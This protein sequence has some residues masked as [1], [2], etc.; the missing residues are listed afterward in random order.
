MYSYIHPYIH[1]CILTSLHPYIPTNL[2][3]YMPAYLHAYMHTYTHLYTYIPNASIQHIYTCIYTYTNIR[4][5]TY[6]HLYMYVYED[7]CVAILAQVLA[8][9]VSAWVKRALAQDYEDWWVTI[10]GVMAACFMAPMVDCRSC[11]QLYI[12]GVSKKLTQEESCRKRRCNK[13]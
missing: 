6:I 5:Y 12:I 1:T 7:M 4:S 8:R 2:Q 3:T 13:M 9:P 11:C 10:K